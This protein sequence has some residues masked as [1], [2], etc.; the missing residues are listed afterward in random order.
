[1][2]YKQGGLGHGLE[3]IDGRRN[4]VGLGKGRPCP[5]DHPPRTGGGTIQGHEGL[6]EP[7]G[8][9][10]K[11][12]RQTPQGRSVL[13]PQRIQ[14]TVFVA[15][16]ARVLGP[17][18][19]KDAAIGEI[20]VNRGQACGIERGQGQFLNLKVRLQARMAKQLTAHLKRL[21]MGEQARSLCVHHRPGVAEPGE[22][23]LAQQVGIHPGGL[24]RDVGPKTQQPAR[25]SIG[26]LEAAPL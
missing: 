18:C 16:K 6:A 10:C 2:P 23:G 13:P 12:S 26:E 25:C 19:Q 11:A 3:S 20:Q 4:G 21:T 8:L 14:H 7:Q 17:K 5:L 22:A 24:R 1:M 9:G 15:R